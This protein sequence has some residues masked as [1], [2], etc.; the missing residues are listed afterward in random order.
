VQRRKFQRGLFHVLNVL[1]L[2][3]P[4]LRERPEDIPLLVERFR[5]ISARRL[6]RDLPT[7]SP[8]CWSV[9]QNHHWPGNVRELQDTIERAM[10]HCPAGVLEPAHLYVTI[11]AL[12]AAAPGPMEP[13]V[14]TLDEAE[15]RHTLAV[16][17]RCHENRT[18]AAKRLGITLRALRYK[19][20]KF[21][22]LTAAGT[23]EE[24]DSR[25]PR[26]NRPLIAARSKRH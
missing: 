8:A 25:S 23:N 12:G 2:R 10:L 21:R 9:L 17:A 3:V 14:E 20:R 5:E 18:H 22:L 26:R 16:L 24:S 15:M 13:E 11:G 6:G 19:L 7:V 4:P 1:S